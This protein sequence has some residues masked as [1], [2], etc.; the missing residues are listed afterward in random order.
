MFALHRCFSSMIAK[1]LQWDWFELAPDSV[2]GFP[3]D[4][5]LP[6]RRETVPHVNGPQHTDQALLKKIAVWYKLETTQETRAYRCAQPCR[7]RHHEQLRFN[8]LL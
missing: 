8:V 4:G 5:T 7:L 3:E 6:K 1:G 2:H